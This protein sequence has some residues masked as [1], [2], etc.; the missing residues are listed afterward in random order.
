MP[1][2]TTAYENKEGTDIVRR[3]IKLQHQRQKVNYFKMKKTH[4]GGVL[5]LAQCV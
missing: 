3:C 1:N 4:G 2:Y 5:V